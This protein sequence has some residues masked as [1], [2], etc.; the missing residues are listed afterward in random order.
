MKA[1]FIEPQFKYEIDGRHA[2]TFT[3]GAGPV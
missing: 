2:F 3:E 1:P